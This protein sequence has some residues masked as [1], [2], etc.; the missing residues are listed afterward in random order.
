M[1]ASVIIVNWN[2][3][4]FL[5]ECLFTLFAQKRG[6]FEAIVVDNASTDNSLAFV[7]KHYPQAKIIRNGRNVGFAR[8]NNVGAGAAQGDFLVFL[9]YDATVEPDWLET[10]LAPM[11]RDASIGATSSKV[12][13]YSR[14]DLIN[15]AGTFFS[16]IGVSGSLGDAV[17]RSSFSEAFELFAPCGASFAIRRGLYARIGGFDE[18]YFLYDEDVDL[19]WKVWNSGLRVVFV[20]ESVAYHRYAPSQKAYKYYYIMRNKFWTVWKNA[21]TRD[22]IWLLPMAFASS[23]AIAVLFVVFLK[24]GAAM[25][26]FRG[27]LD[28][29]KRL[30]PRFS[31]RTGDAMGRMLWL[32]G[33][34]R[35]FGRKFK[36]HFMG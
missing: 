13:Y 34:V 4:K 21:R 7:E 9:N 16:F 17:P 5:P 35:V 19:G 33:T 14:R 23:L 28:A 12:I 22:A 32:G 31:P 11:E 15:S 27:M 18:S 30:P 25:A 2:G 3:E 24:P 1:R 10:L 36:K 20:P 8:A 6:G 26:S 29:F